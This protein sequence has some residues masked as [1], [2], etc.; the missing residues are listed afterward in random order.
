MPIFTTSDVDRDWLQI[1][2]CSG[3]CGGA[4][5]ISFVGDSRWRKGDRPLASPVRFPQ[6]YTAVMQQAGGLLPLVHHI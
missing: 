4:C 3:V 5:P 6:N 2:D 1:R